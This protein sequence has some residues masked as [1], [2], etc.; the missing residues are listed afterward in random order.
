[1][2]KEPNVNKAVPFFGIQD[3][4]RSL[5]FYR[6]GLGFTMRHSWRPEGRLR[7]CWLDLDAASI[8]LQE[9]LEG[10][11]PEGALGQG[12]SICFMCQ[13]A[14]AICRDALAKGLEPE[15]PFV[16]NGLW[17]TGFTDPDGYKL[18]FESP[19]DVPE[20]TKLSEVMQL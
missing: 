15:E 16:G 17:V 1:M 3:M 9:Y 4:D 8:M 20:E 14:L 19:A 10:K 7:W 13:D 5:A 6:D 18:F 2:S 11:R 12:I